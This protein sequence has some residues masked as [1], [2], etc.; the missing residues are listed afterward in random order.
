MNILIIRF[1]SIGDIVLTTAFIRQVRAAFPEARIDYLI[2]KPFSQLIRYNPHINT[3]YTFDSSSKFSGLKSLREEL[4]KNDYRFIFDLQNNFLSNYI[5]K[6]FPKAEIGQIDKLKV[7]RALLVYFK[8]NRYREIFP[9]PLRY[10]KTAQFAGVKDDRLGL[11]L[12]LGGEI[13]PP[14][15]NGKYIAL[16]PG[17]AHYTKRWPIERFKELIETITNHFNYSIVLLGGKEDVETPSSLESLP[18]LINYCGKL[19][20]LESA[21]VIK[22]AQLLISN[23]SSLMHIAAAVKTPIA[24]IFGSTSA[25]LGFFPFRAKSVVIEKKLWCRPCTHIGRKSCPLGHFKCM[26]EIMADDVFR[27]VENLINERSE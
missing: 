20:L 4:K 6:A 2:K 15:I 16:A 1:S 3:I 12:F 19:T 23:D 10:L 8:I 24:A 13:K 11:E 14:V 26:K 9:V 18:H 25:E 17:A 5:L 21:A 7:N 27:A 22:N